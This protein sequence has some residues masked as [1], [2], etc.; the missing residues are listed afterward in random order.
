MNNKKNK[1]TVGSW[2]QC[3]NANSTELISKNNFGWHCIDFEHGVYDFSNIQDIIRSIKLNKKKCFVRTMSKNV[4]EISKL[5]DMGID[6]VFIPK[7]ESANEVRKIHDAIYYYPKGNRGVAYSRS[8]VYGANFKK[9]LK[10]SKKNLIIGMIETKLGVDNL[11]SILNCKLLNG[12]FIGP[13]DL[14][15]SLGAPGNF[16]TKKFKNALSNILKISKEF[17]IPCGIHVLDK[18]L[19]NY[20]KIIKKGYSFIAYMTDSITISNYKPL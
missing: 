19:K 7:I 18:K 17:K 8:N 14:S 3:S 16:K 20:K 1:F 5:M 6:G 15:S 2:I 4:N 11:K 12:V 9:Y 10:N 13:Y